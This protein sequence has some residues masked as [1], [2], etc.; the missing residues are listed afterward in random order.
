VELSESINSMFKWYLN[1][2]VCLA[3]LAD[4]DGKDDPDGLGR[5]VWFSRGWTLQELLAPQTVVFLTQAW[6]TIG[7]KGE[8]RSQ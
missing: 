4:V 8:N 2:E 6:K 1:A 5:S 3:Y 7:H